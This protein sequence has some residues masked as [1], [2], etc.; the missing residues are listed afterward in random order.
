MILKCHNGPFLHFGLDFSKNLRKLEKFTW[1]HLKGIAFLQK[2]VCF[3]GFWTTI[4]KILALE[5]QAFLK[6]V[7]T[8]L[9]ILSTF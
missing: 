1:M 6:I 8:F 9:D 2:M 3:I 7:G 5:L 4:L